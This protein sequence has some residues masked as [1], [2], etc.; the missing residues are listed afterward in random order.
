M[1]GMVAAA[2]APLVAGGTS[3]DGEGT[4]HLL[5]QA[6]VNRCREVATA[7]GSDAMHHRGDPGAA[8]VVCPALAGARVRRP[9]L[10]E[11]P[12]WAAWWLAIRGTMRTALLWQWLRACPPPRGL[13]PCGT[14]RC[15]VLLAPGTRWVWHR[16]GL[17]LGLLV[18]AG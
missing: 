2:L 5:L 17:A 18:F 13:V 8:L 11:A 15:M 6:L 14:G 9:G 10:A 4:H 16:R 12:A 7:L 3:L 1:S